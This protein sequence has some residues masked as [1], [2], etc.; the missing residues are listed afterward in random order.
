MSRLRPNCR[1]TAAGL[2]MAT[3]KL[4]ARR[5]ICTCPRLRRASRNSTLLLRSAATIVGFREAALSRVF[6]P[7]DVALAG[8]GP[9]CGNQNVD[10]SQIGP[11]RPCA[12]NDKARHEN[13]FVRMLRTLTSYSSTN[14]WLL[15][16]GKLRQA[17]CVDLSS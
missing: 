14:A 2:S 12:E 15:L 10:M 6:P 11:A 4:S 8:I 16:V 5:R 1:V 3:I 13:A 7:Q 9:A 17:R